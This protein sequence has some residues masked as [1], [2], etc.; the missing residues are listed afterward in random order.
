MTQSIALTQPIALKL[1]L[2]FEDAD[3]NQ[4]AEIDVRNAKSIGIENVPEFRE[5]YNKPTD[6]KPERVIIR[7]T[8]LITVN[9]E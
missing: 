3:K 9:Y 8:Y 6:L 2:V 1:I 7:N 5:L 4:E